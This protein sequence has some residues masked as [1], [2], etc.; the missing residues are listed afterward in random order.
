MKK[1]TNKFVK[2]LMLVSMIF[3][4]FQTP[5]QVFAKEIANNDS[6]IPVG[7]IKLG[8]NGKIEESG[9]QVRQLQKMV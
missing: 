2:V 8:E 1:I 9:M 6:E 3:S 5:I 4:S 7:S